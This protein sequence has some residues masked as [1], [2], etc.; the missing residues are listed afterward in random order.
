[1]LADIDPPPD[2]LVVVSRRSGIELSVV[3]DRDGSWRVA[4]AAMDRALMA[5]AE[6]MIDALSGEDRGEE[7]RR[8]RALWMARIRTAIW[9]LMTETEPRPP[10]ALVAKRMGKVRKDGSPNTTLREH[11]RPEGGWQAVLDTCIALGPP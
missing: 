6:K 1:L 11:L 7:W 8:T 9:D 10:F 3:R 2:L 4:T 5:Q